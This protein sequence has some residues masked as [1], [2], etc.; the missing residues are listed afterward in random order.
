MRAIEAPSMARVPGSRAGALLQA[1]A[2]YI[3]FARA[4]AI[5]PDT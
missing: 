2:A 3:G 5:S 4:A 1:R